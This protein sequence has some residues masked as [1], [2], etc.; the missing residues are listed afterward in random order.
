[1]TG[2]SAQSPKIGRPRHFA[3]EVE[4]AM[5]LD[6]AMRVLTKRAYDATS[7]NDILTEAGL[8]TRAFYRHFAAKRELLEALSERECERVAKALRRAV[9][10]ADDPI[11]AIDAWLE[12]FLDVYYEPKR[13]ARVAVFTSASVRASYSEP[14]AAEAMRDLFCKPLIQA[15]RAGH[16][17][18]LFH[19]PDPQ[20]D[21]R[22]IYALVSNVTHRGQARARN[23]SAARAQVLRF[24]RPALGL[25]LDDARVAAQHPPVRQRASR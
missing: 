17:S 11:A 10:E 4:R 2:A 15:L 8:S 9:A 24:V 21:A 12:C 22:S 16:K 18:G 23:R 7:V 19:S 13:A 20:E 3:P 1:M 25:P 14:S 5:L 6:A